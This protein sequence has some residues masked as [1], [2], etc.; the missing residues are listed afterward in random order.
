MYLP[1]HYHEQDSEQL[2][3]LMAHHGFATLV[4]AG[5]GIPFAT[6]V[7]LLAERHPVHGDRLL[8]HMARANPQWRSFPET[9]EAL[10]IFHG[11]HAYVSP[12]YYVT[13]P[14][15]PTWNYATVH[16]YGTPRVI[17]EPSEV[18]RILREST[19]KYESGAASPWSPEQAPDYVARLLAGIVAFE[20][21]LT[22]LEGKFKLSQNRSE[23][24]RRGVIQALQDSPSPEDRA[25]AALM[26]EREPRSS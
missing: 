22:R 15:V 1:R 11:P 4:T 3:A 9:R 7:P 14:H 24:D 18:L 21:R 8:G 12:R 26:R 20:L 17:E 19:A 16:A 5:D 2:F 23:E 6:H 13:A 10:A 25:L